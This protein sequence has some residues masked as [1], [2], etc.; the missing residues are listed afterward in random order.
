MSC[1]RLRSSST[2]LRRWGFTERS[3]SPKFPFIIRFAPGR[4][5][6]WPQAPSPK[7]SAFE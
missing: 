7:C 3:A 2:F 6:E 4:A 5:S 1:V